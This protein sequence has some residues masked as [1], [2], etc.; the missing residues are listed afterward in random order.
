MLTVTHKTTIPVT[1][2]A[3]LQNSPDHPEANISVINPE[4]VPGT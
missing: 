2:A 3:E 1:Q 4:P